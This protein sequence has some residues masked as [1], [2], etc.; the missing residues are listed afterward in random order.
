MVVLERVLALGGREA[1]GPELGV[2][3]IEGSEIKLTF[4]F[5]LVFILILITSQEKKE[6]LNE[7][8]KAS[9]RI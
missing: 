7:R 1:R 5:L 2:H 8:K 4:F 9:L 6:K 3:W